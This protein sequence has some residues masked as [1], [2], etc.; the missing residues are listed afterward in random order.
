M[1][2]WEPKPL[3]NPLG[4]TGPV[5]GLLYLYLFII[6]IANVSFL[7]EAFELELVKFDLLVSL[8]QVFF[9][10]LF[11]QRRTGYIK[12]LRTG[13]QIWFSLSHYVCSY[14]Q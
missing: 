6:F 1:E 2:I 14:W 5:T 3:G 13:L 10:F 7:L 8:L 4:H 9:S 11:L 12:L